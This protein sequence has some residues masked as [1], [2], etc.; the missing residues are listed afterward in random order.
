[1]EINKLNFNPFLL[2][3]GC[4]FRSKFIHEELHGHFALMA[5][6]V[7]DIPI[8]SEILSEKSRW[9]CAQEFRSKLHSG[10]NPQ[11]L[12]FQAGKVDENCH[13]TRSHLNS[14]GKKADDR[15]QE[16]RSEIRSRRILLRL[17]D[18]WMYA[19]DKNSFRKKGDDRTHKNSNRKSRWQLKKLP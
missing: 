6:K 14:F 18:I 4:F 3:V 12:L 16:F 8:P 15:S 1:M 2:K 9:P 5:R 11:H 17:D 7:D 19:N 13:S 10:R